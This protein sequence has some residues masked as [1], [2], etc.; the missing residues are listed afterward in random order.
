MKNLTQN[1][2][3][4]SY[5]LDQQHIQWIFVLLSIGLLIVGAAAPLSGGGSIPPVS[6]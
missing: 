5:K 2:I 1:L 4:V 6:K 3:G